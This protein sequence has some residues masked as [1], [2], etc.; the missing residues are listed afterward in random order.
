MA[1]VSYGARLSYGAQASTLRDALQTED[2][3]NCRQFC[4]QLEEKQRTGSD[5]IRSW[6]LTAA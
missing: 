5:R 3:W 2:I 4:K 1:Q 6:P